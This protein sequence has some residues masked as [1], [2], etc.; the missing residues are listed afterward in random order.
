[1][2]LQRN[3]HSLWK[4]LPKLCAAFKIGEQNDKRAGGLL[5]EYRHYSSPKTKD[6]DSFPTIIVPIVGYSGSRNF[7]RI[8]LA[9]S[10]DNKVLKNELT[11][12]IISLLTKLR[13]TRYFDA[14]YIDVFEVTNASYLVCIEEGHSSPPLNLQYIT[15]TAFLNHQA[16]H[17]D[18][19]MARIYCEWRGARLPTEAE[20]EKAARR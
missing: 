2:S 6:L 11:R 7:E 15:N 18:W 14:Y 13:C 8:H 3:L 9:H 10:E 19:D 5:R 16:V 1:M 20:W 12:I 4:P 17:V